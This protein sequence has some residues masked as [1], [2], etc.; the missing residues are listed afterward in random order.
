VNIKEDIMGYRYMMDVNDV[1]NELEVKKSK[2]YEIIRMLNREL[3]KEGYWSVRGR[4]PRAY[5]ETK[6]YGHSV[7]VA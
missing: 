4:I 1:M 3:E 5:W 7:A 6:Y 2:A